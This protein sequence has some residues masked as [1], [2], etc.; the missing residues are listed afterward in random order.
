VAAL[1]GVL[2][3]ASGGGPGDD[4]R[5]AAAGS[6]T[7]A[8]KSRQGSLTVMS[9]GPCVL[10]VLAASARGRRRR[11]MTMVVRVFSSPHKLKLDVAAFCP[12]TK[13]HYPPLNESPAGV[14]GAHTHRH[15][16]RRDQLTLDLTDIRLPTHRQSQC[17]GGRA[18]RAG[19]AE[20]SPPQPLRANVSAPA[21][22]TTVSCRSICMCTGVPRLFAQG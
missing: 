18:R 6:R 14:L 17:V 10:V 22:L 13:P 2:V 4:I 9:I 3:P 19:R 1:G 21:A 16:L 12:R 11:R 8:W 20:S 5:D 15:E 7:R